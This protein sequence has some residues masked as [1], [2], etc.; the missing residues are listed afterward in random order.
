MLKGLECFGCISA[1]VIGMAIDAAVGVNASVK[2]SFGGVF[3]EKT[4]CDIFDT[5]VILFVAADTLNGGHSGKWF[6]ATQ[7]IFFFSVMGFH[8]WARIK[9]HLGEH[10]CQCGQNDG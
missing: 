5:D 1:S 2:Q 9:Q 6:V 3:W 4:T 8:Q 7:T 10:C